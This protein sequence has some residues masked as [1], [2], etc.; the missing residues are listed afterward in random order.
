MASQYNLNLQNDQDRV[1]NITWTPPVDDSTLTEENL[2]ESQ[3]PTEEFPTGG[4]NE[5]PPITPFSGNVNFNKTIYSNTLFKG[6]VNSTFSELVSQDSVVD[7]PAFFSNYNRIFFDIPK[8]GEN[9]HTTLVNSSK[10]YINDYIDPKDSI[11]ANLENLIESLEQQLADLN[12]EINQEPEEH[13]LFKNGTIVAL[14]NSSRVFYMDK[15]YAR[16]IDYNPKFWEALKLSLYG[17]NDPQYPRINLTMFETL[18]RG[19]PNLSQQNFSEYWEPDTFVSDILDSILDKVQA[20]DRDGMPNLQ[21]QNYNDKDS[22]FNALYQDIT[23]KNAQIGLL[24][25]ER[26]IIQQ[27]IDAL[28]V[29]EGASNNNKSKST[30]NSSKENNTGT[31][32]NTSGQKSNV[33]Y[34]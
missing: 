25:Q 30:S 31:N 33:S 23:Q 17:T 10:E 12:D 2:N 16:E 1:G 26:N 22:F 5:N 15:G 4:D 6:K 34:R 3:T 32:T 24:Q 11:I 9:S 18:K 13:P 28:L 20:L 8:E 21:P 27:E 14:D 7:I 29:L 19:F